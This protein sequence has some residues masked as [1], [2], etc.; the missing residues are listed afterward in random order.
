MKKKV[1]NTVATIQHHLA[2]FK[3]Y[4]QCFI[5]R[6]K[7]I[8]HR[9]LLIVNCTLY[10]ANCY[11]QP[12]QTLIDL[13]VK[14]NSEL[15]ALESEYL[16]ALERAP[17]V[18]QLP[19]PEFGV[20]FYPLPVE[21]RLGAQTTRFS[22]TQMF[23]WFG[24]LEAK[25]QLENTRAQALH[26]R[27]AARALEVSFE[28]KQAYFRL[29]QIQQSQSIIL[30]NIELLEVLERLALAKVES[31]KATAADVLQ[32][33]LKIKELNQEV[34]ILE[35]EKASPTAK[36]NQL[37]NRFLATPINTTDSLSFAQIPFNKGAL[38]DQ[39]KATHPMLRMFAIQQE[40]SQRAIAVNTLEGKPSFGLGLDYTMVSQRTDMEPTNNGRDILQLRATVKIPL[41]RKKYEAKEQEENFKIA[42]LNQQKTDLL[43]K[44]NASIE[45]AYADYEGARLRAE[46]Y[47]Q[48]KEITQAAIQILETDYSTQGSSF[49]ELLRLEKELIDYD[50]KMLKTIVES[51]IALAKIE[52][53]LIQ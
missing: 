12:L 39:I 2:C 31:G 45:S 36:I 7:R 33:Q 35:W 1:L 21:T 43:S 37:L 5:R 16:A 44:F 52:R 13:A 19:D 10:I 50:L 38:S 29:Y 40:A 4:A 51:H 15:K 47:Q 53:Y 30:R 3:G 20:G 23:P 11:T 42:A 34:L 48:Q 32:V 25:E 18:S 24:A 46:L 6:P 27:V 17:Q 14:E 41:N 22:A 28:V 26:E 9:T 8:V 49:D